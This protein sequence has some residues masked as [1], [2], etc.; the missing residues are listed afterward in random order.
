LLVVGAG[1]VGLAAAFRPRGRSQVLQAENHV[2]GRVRP[3]AWDGFSL[4]GDVGATC[5]P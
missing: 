3:T 4:D 5:G 2:G 1:S